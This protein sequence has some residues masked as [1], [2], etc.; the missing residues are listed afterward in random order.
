MS[1]QPPSILNQPAVPRSTEEARRLINLP[2]M[3][4]PPSYDHTAEPARLCRLSSDDYQTLFDSILT[5]NLIFVVMITAV[6]CFG[7]Y[8]FYLVILGGVQHIL[9][10][11]FLGCT[12]ATKTE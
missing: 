7:L 2:W 8:W 9:E 10:S 12:N 6:L 5:H 4:P 11:Q 1:D 3:P